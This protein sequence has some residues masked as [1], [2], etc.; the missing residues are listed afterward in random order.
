[1]T[2]S[3]LSEAQTSLSQ[4]FALSQYPLLR[5]L[6]LILF[7]EVLGWSMTI[8][9]IAFFAIHDLGL[10]AFQLGATISGFSCGQILGSAFCGRSSDAWGRRPVIVFSFLWAG[11]LLVAT[12]WV[13]SFEE[14]LGC[15]ILAG[16]SGGTFT[17]VQAYTLDVVDPPQRG[18]YLGIL[19]AY[20]SFGF[21]L[22]PGI[23]AG[24]MAL[25]LLTRK[26]VF[27]ASG[28]LGLVGAVIAYYCMWESLPKNR[29]RPW[30]STPQSSS[31]WQAVNL[32]L[33]L[34]W[35][36]RFFAS[37]GQ[38]MLYSMYAFLLKDMFG[39]ADV[40][41]GMIFTGAG[42]WGMLVQGIIFPAADRV[43]GNHMAAA[44]GCSFMAAGLS[45]LPVSTSL[46]WHLL[47]MAMFG[48]GAGLFDPS[49][50]VL[51]AS[52]VSEKHLGFANGWATSWRAVAS[53]FSPLLAGL[54]FE[55]CGMCTFFCGRS[56]MR[57]CW[58]LRSRGMVL[59]RR[60]VRGPRNRPSS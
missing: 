16:L 9:V 29:R 53:V 38:L 3:T 2:A 6:F 25:E 7:L 39:F 15:R 5:P 22:G 28:S 34:V 20:S 43:L 23:A 18:S 44:L 42:L 10:T 11:A 17:I 8:P 57:C 13:R 49:V 37:F 58:M 55:R 27:I 56:S 33:V 47:F 45:L 35:V 14:L 36:A 1:M 41:M 24:L 52:C 59:H 31:D 54:L 19:G 50:P 60:D 32:A 26:G 40:E 21:A 46:A 51:V 4:D 30:L 48:L 12:A